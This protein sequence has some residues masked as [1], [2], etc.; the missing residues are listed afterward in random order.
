MSETNLCVYLVYEFVCVCVCL[1]ISI[2]L[3]VV[4]ERDSGVTATPG[5]LTI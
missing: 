5:N 1:C 2:C 3:Y 4:G